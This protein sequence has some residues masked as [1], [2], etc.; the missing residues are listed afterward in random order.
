MVVYPRLIAA[1]HKSPVKNKLV[2]SGLAEL[3]HLW[4]GGIDAGTST[5]LI[6][7][8][9]CGKSTVAMRYAVTAAERG[10]KSIIFS[11]DETTATLLKRAT[12]LGMDLRP[13]IDSGHVLMKQI[14][15]AEMPAGEF[16]AE[17]RNAVENT[18]CSIVILDSL[19]GLINAMPGEQFL[20]LQMHE[21]ISYLN[22]MGVNTFFTMAQSGFVSAHMVSPVDVSYLADS[23]LL[24]RYFESMGEVKRALSVVKKRSGQHERA[25]RELNFSG[26]AL[27][28]GAPLSQFEGILTGNPRFVGK[29]AELEIFGTAK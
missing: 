27:K 7:P 5:L 3:D 4:G 12:G 14:D 11:F 24:F 13:H 6:G 22:Q 9:G 29:S 16:T 21:M 8:A 19:N 23:V 20:M 15:P 28:V 17:V 1:E 10:E 25:I 18:G 2:P 26:G